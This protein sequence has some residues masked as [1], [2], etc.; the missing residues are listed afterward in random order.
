MK[1]FGNVILSLILLTLV[2]FVSGCASQTTTDR[3]TTETG[4]KLAEWKDK[5]LADN[6]PDSPEYIVAAGCE[7]LMFQSVG[8]CS[9][10]KGWFV[11]NQMEITD[12][13]TNKRYSF[14]DVDKGGC[15]DKKSDGS[16]WEK[17]NVNTGSL[18][19]QTEK[20][21]SEYQVVCNVLCVWWNCEESIPSAVQE[22]W[23]GTFTGNTIE[24]CHTASEELSGTYTVQF[25]VK[26]KL[27]TA[28]QSDDQ[29]LWV[30]PVDDSD[31][32]ASGTESVTSQSTDSDCQLVGGS[33][34]S[35]PIWVNAGKQR[36]VIFSQETFN[37]FMTGKWIFQSSSSGGQGASLELEP[38]SIT[39]S[40]IS[41]AWTATGVRSGTFTLTKQG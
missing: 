16:E 30:D 31:G 37:Y 21:S 26:K 8:E 36:F 7:E 1:Y 4:G 23:T 19:S 40:S 18:D 24:M 9:Q 10:Y 38:V 14:Q 11:S 15:P 25:T 12:F 39:D 13:K 27:A 20:G 41:G 33:A 17:H 5:I 29:S 35:I 34:T 32:T 2:I 3:E 6:G 22:T 28:L